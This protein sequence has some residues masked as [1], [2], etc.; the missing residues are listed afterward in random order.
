M[1]ASQIK[2]LFEDEIFPSFP[3]SNVNWLAVAFERDDYDNARMP[4]WFFCA[5][6]RRFNQDGENKLLIMGEPVVSPHFSQETADIPFDWEHY[7]NFMLSTER[8]A[9]E[10]KMAS[11]DRKC[12][13][14]TDSEMTIFGGVP[15]KMIELFNDFG[16]RNAMLAHIEQEFF[17][18]EPSGY[19]DMRLF[20]RGLLFPEH[21]KTSV[22]G[23]WGQK[24][25]VE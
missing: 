16:G 8:S 25:W 13:C 23:R 18:D 22:R 19:E 1:I 11:E 14:W 7:R 12:G 20:L 17:L 6:T 10:Y 3:F 2:D 9:V 21:R 4:E 24:Q 15:E 5:A